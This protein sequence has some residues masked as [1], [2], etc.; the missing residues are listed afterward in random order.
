MLSRMLLARGFHVEQLPFSR[1][2]LDFRKA[3]SL[4]G[5]WNVVKSPNSD[6]CDA[7]VGDAEYPEWSDG[8]RA[9]GLTSAN[10][11]DPP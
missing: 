2:F 7:E 9:R 4:L 1:N 10:R 11:E 6:T 8:Q 5:I 3:V